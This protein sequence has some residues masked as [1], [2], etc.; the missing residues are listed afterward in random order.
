MKLWDKLLVVIIVI[1]SVF[2]FACVANEDIEAHRSAAEAVEAV[3]LSEGEVA[4]REQQA[5]YRGWRDG[6]QYYLDRF[7]GTS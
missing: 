2:V 5:Y 7:G 1:G 4:R 3:I 6:K